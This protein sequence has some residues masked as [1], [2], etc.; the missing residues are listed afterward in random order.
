[1]NNIFELKKPCQAEL[2]ELLAVWQESVKE[3]HTFL[4]SEDIN[5][6]KPFVKEGLMNIEKFL[7]VRDK[8]IEAFMAIDGCK[9]EM[10]FISPAFI[11]KGLGRAMVKY[12]IELGVKFV[13]VNEQNIKAVGFYEHLGFKTFK[14]DDTD[15][16]GNPFPI[17]HMKLSF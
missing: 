6:I 13:D 4:T 10:L 8:K 16:Q 2:S 14:R 11:G 17:L 5:S 7:C 15:S 9:L 1:M 3:T 12:A